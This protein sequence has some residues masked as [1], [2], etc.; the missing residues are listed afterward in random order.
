[1]DQI[2]LHAL[3][4]TILDTAEQPA[5]SDVHE[6]YK[7]L[8]TSGYDFCSKLVNA[9]KQLQVK[10]NKAKGYGIIT[11]DDTIVLITVAN[12]KWAARQT[13][14]TGNFKDAQKTISDKYPV[15]HVHDTT[16]CAAIMTTLAEADKAHTGMAL[17]VDKGIRFLGALTDRMD[18]N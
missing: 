15:S 9:V 10:A 8:I 18:H 17:V 11:N 3:L 12:V 14:G 6:E 4:K 13:W 5:V 1:M 7:A 16:S 2:E